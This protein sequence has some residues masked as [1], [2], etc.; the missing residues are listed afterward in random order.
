MRNL[1]GLFVV[2]LTVCACGNKQAQ[3]NI[4]EDSTPWYENDSLLLAQLNAAIQDAKQ[5]DASKISKNLMPVKKGTPER[6]GQPL[7]GKTW[8]CW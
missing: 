7:T 8:C 5:L 2:L 4:A 6:N 1:I 3:T